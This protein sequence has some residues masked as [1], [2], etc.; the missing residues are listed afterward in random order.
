M[1]SAELMRQQQEQHPQAEHNNQQEQH[2][3]QVEH[4]NLQQVAVV[5]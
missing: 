2:N 4:N 5:L 1:L 3:P